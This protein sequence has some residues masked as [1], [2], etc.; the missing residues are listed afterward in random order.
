MKMDK[1]GSV[2]IDKSIRIRVLIDVRKALM[3]KVKIK[4]RGGCEEYFDVKYEKPPIILLLLWSYGAWLKD[5]DDYKEEEDECLKF[6]S[7]LKASPW[8][9]AI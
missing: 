6:G 9:Q 2:G 1:S 4:M 5:C 8:K 3:Q 7:W